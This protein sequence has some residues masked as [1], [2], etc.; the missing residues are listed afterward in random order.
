MNSEL[1][2]TL[3]VAIQPSVG[4]KC[5]LL[6]ADG[7]TIELPNRKELYALVRR[8]KLTIVPQSQLLAL[9][10]SGGGSRYSDRVIPSPSGGDDFTCAQWKRIARMQERYRVIGES[11]EWW[12]RMCAGK[13]G[14]VIESLLIT[15]N[16]VD[17]TRRRRN[18]FYPDPLTLLME[19][20]RA[21]GGYDI[22]LIY[23]KLCELYG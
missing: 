21:V 10:G 14:S 5:R 20:C 7:G 1:D 19:A 17:A 23:F 3:C 12:R 22:W 18:K 2:S 9:A 8:E 13:P 15:L 16:H 6:M 11:W 4:G